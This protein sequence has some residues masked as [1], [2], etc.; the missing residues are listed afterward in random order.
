M[1]ISD[2]DSLALEM[3]VE[4]VMLLVYAI[5]FFYSQTPAVEQMEWGSLEIHHQKA[6][7]F[8]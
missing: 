4:S 3:C 1:A 6:D 7:P 2:H 8:S 5:F